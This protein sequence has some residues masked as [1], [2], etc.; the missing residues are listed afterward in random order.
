[1]TRVEIRGFEFTPATIEVPVGTTVVWTNRDDIAHTATSGTTR[2][3]GIGTYEASPDG[4]FAGVMSGAGTEYRFRFDRP[5]TYA[6][7]CDRHRH[8]TATVVVR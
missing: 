2:S 1:M 3:T 6:Y 8:M 4:A 7:F 5:G